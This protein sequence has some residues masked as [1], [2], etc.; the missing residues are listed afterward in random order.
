M[1]I[2][3]LSDLH[4]EMQ[5]AIDLPAPAADVCILAGD[6]DRPLTRSVE[7]AATHIA[8]HMPALLVAGNHEFYGDGLHEGFARAR[9]R[10]GEVP[11]VHLLERDAV[12]IGGVRFLGA[13]L[14]TDYALFAGAAP[15]PG[16]TEAIHQAMTAAWKQLNDHRL[17]RADHEDEPWMPKHALAEHRLARAFLE[18]ALAG[19]PGNRTVVVTHHAPIPASIAPQYATD[20]LSTAFASDLSDLIGRHQP[21][22]WVHGHVHNTV[23]TT[24]GATRIVCNPRGY[25]SENPAFN[26]ALVVEMAPG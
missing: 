23:D 15:E 21:A 13:T 4:L 2:W 18:E 8:P 14:W 22:L 20:I 25:R 17:I 3:I 9:E 1:R 11:G 5:D 19:G 6:I 7:W 24:V 26:P 16:R 12:E 10:A